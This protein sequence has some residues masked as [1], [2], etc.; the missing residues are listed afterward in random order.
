MNDNMLEAVGR[1]L[2]DLRDEFQKDVGSL[3]L[4][5]SD[6]A[7]HLAEAIDQIQTELNEARDSLVSTVESSVQK[8]RDEFEAWKDL[9]D[10]FLQRI[11][12][13]KKQ[14]E[15]QFEKV[16]DEILG[17]TERLVGASDA[18]ELQ[19]TALDQVELSLRLALE[20]VGNQITEVRE[21]PRV[22]PKD[23][24]V[25]SGCIQQLET[26]ITDAKATIGEGINKVEHDLRASFEE[27]LETVDGRV[28][29]VR[30]SLRALAEEL[31]DILKDKLATYIREN[32]E[33]CTGYLEEKLNAS[34]LALANAML[35]KW[36][37]VGPWAQGGPPYAK[38]SIVKHRNGL[39]QAS[40][41]TSDE[42]GVESPWVLLVD[43]VERVSDGDG[44]HAE[45]HYCSGRV[46]MISLP[47]WAPRFLKTWG[48]DT[49]YAKDDSVVYDRHRWIA[50]KD[51][52]SGPPNKSDD[53]VVFA[54]QGARGRKGE[55]G[56]EGGIGPSL[57]RESL[58]EDVLRAVEARKRS[59]TWWRGAWKFG[60]DYESGQAVSSK[61][62]LWYCLKDND[63][64]VNP[65]QPGSTVWEL[66]L[67]VR[68]A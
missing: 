53:W 62:A 31:P 43:G 30:E 12:Q 1:I 19:G 5:Q 45:V 21:L 7:N 38:S 59:M 9:P 8:L 41:D 32:Q 60:E 26:A 47:R 54:M 14:A 37:V 57:D 48:Q 36:A 18:I 51:N 50:V 63:G 66:M 23:L 42:P 17:L 49:E 64:T 29:H 25:V 39:W 58:V 46:D 35:K 56:P 68:D 15:T 28:D 44:E 13:A 24:T 4:R 6:Q 3:Q 34:H 27:Q 10:D 40:E 16:Y 20:D 65:G 11:E 61:G 55:Q 52:P 2:R 22:D 67:M 33:Q